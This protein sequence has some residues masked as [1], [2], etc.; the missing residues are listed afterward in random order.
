MSHIRKW[1]RVP[2]LLI[3]LAIIVLVGCAASGGDASGQS[4]TC[5]GASCTLNGGTQ[6]VTISV[7]PA[8]GDTPIVNAI[9]HAQKS[10]WLE[11]YLLT[12]HNV[13]D[14]LESAA[15]RGLDVRVMLEPHPVG[16]GSV[17]PQETLTALNAAGV[18]ARSTSPAFALT[19]AKL[20]IIDQTSAFID[21]AND[22]KTALG[23]TS[24]IAD[25]DYLI[26]DTDAADVAESAAIFTADWNHTTPTLSNP[27]LVV[28][29]VNARPKLTTLINSAKI[30]LHLEEEE[31]QDSA[32]IAA[33]IAAK[34]RGVNV[35]L[36][37]PVPDKGS[38]DAKG[39]GQLQAAGI[40]VRQLGGN[41]YMHAK[42]I[43]ADGSLAYVGSVNVSTQS[44]DHNR[45]V[46]V[47]I[48]NAEAISILEKTFTKD[49]GN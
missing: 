32:I 11:I 30:S 38:A 16:S 34:Q 35:Q 39:E 4:I 10:V 31:M 29:P 5:V 14:A 49:I 2:T 24:T 8:A 6:A 25:R 37:V 46:G 28:S 17:T 36:V 13:I 26:L 22:T 44:L 41:L 19:H 12:E 1:A 20:M 7:E 47:L 48:A 9:N 18:Q 23:G 33:L 45:E 15:N 21:S 43:I 3:T 42:L 40:K 27:H